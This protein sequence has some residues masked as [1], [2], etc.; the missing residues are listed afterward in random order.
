MIRWRML[1]AMTFV[2]IVWKDIKAKF[3][4]KYAHVTL[5]VFLN[6]YIGVFNCVQIC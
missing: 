1:E 3:G 2:V 6:V 5:H 4:A